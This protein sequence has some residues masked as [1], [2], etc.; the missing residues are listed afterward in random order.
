[1]CEKA[2]LDLPFMEI[3]VGCGSSLVIMLILVCL[4]RYRN[5]HKVIEPLPTL[6]EEKL[7]PRTDMIQFKGDLKDLQLRVKKN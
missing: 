3:V 1:V 6:E 7:L 4:Y 2:K 5:S